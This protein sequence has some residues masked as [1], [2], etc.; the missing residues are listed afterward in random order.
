MSE[1]ACFNQIL[2]DEFFERVELFKQ[3]LCT[4]VISDSSLQRTT[5]GEIAFGRRC[6]RCGHFWSKS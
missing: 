2:K 3:F 1:I 6:R 5:C 4:E